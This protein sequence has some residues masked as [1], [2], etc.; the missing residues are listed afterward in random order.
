MSD[1]PEMSDLLDAEDPRFQQVLSCVF[2]IKTHESRTYLTLL[3][4]PGSTVAELADVLDRDRSN[5]NRSLTTLI[6]KGL[7][8]RERRLLDSGGYIYQ[9]TG[10]ELPEAKSMLHDALD[11]WVERVHRSIDDYGEEAA[12]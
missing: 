2:G 7:A 4:H 10:T 8:E 5:I 11:E 9:Y 12:S 1:T 3:D 6:E